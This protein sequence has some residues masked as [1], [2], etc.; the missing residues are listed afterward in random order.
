MAALVLHFWEAKAVTQLSS[1]NKGKQIFRSTK[2]IKSSSS[3]I[4]VMDRHAVCAEQGRM[5]ED[6]R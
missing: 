6:R 5:D 2:D 3:V 4:H 1:T